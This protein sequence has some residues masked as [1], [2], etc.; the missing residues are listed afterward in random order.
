MINSFNC[1]NYKLPIGKKTYIIGIL[2]ITPDSFF[3]GGNYFTRDKAIKHVRKMVEDGADII[4]IGGQ[5]TRPGHKEISV[6]EELDRI[7]PTIEAVS[8]EIDVPISVDTY[9]HQV[10]E[11]VLRAGA[12]IINDIW[13]LNKDPKVAEVAAKYNAGLILMHNQ[14]HNNYDEIMVDIKKHLNECMHMAIS[15]GLKEDNLMIDPGIGA[16]YGKDVTQQYEILARLKELRDL[17]VPI[18]HA[19]SRK[20]FL[21]AITGRE[22]DDRLAATIASVS[23][24]IAHGADFV[25]V[26]DIKEMSDT[27]KVS[28]RIVRR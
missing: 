8:K 23:L 28:D 5:S 2:N 17:N 10:A 12:H 20:S 26:H 13:G 14:S 11:E 16:P 1:R 19:V 9:R 25:R 6:E 21:G 3:D 7:M 4:D 15:A 18:L 22:V 24:G 27:V